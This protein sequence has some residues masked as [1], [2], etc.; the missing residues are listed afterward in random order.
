MSSISQKESPSRSQ[1]TPYI[2]LTMASLFWAGNIVLARGITSLISPV[3][4][5]FT[6]WTLASII[7]L[8]FAWRYIKRDWPVVKENWPILTLLGF[9]GIT[10]F[11][12]LL[13]TAVQTT[14]AINGAIVQ[15]AMPV[16]I[17]VISVLFFGER[18]NAR[19]LVGLALAAIGALIVVTGGSWETLQGLNFVQG[20]LLILLAVTL[21]GLYSICLRRRPE[22]HSLTLVA[23]TFVLGL[24]ILVPFFL[25]ELSVGVRFEFG[26][27]VALSIAYVAIF[28]SI[29]AYL[30]WNGGIARVGANRGGFFVYF[31]PVFAT[32]LSVLF[33]DEVPQIFHLV[34]FILIL[35]GLMSF[36]RWADPDD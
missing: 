6:R 28:P 15:T 24:L 8:P 14:T 13:Y 35:I 19:Q 10:S 33:L 16:I 30:C 7:V 12:T 17:V 23:V 31:L 11:N 29:L 26:S 21:Y 4:L 1:M 18:V 9:L 22:L 20:D 25:W 36:N 2:L 5:A 32:V 3:T 34:G 27:Q